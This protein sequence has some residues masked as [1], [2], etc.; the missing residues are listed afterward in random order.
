[1]NDR[2][3]SGEE[4]VRMYEQSDAIR[5]GG[6]TMDRFR[7]HIDSVGGLTRD[8]IDALIMQ[9]TP[10]TKLSAGNG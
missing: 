8:Q 9:D 1:M 4:C 10:H 6:M 3:L 5:R 7:T 2:L